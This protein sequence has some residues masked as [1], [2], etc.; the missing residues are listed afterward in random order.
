[1]ASETILVVDDSPTILK[2]VQLVLAKAGYEVLTASDGDEGLELAREHTPDLILLDFV[3]PKMNGYQV[4]QVLHN[5][6][7]LAA[8]PVVLMSA[9]GD[10]VG[11]RFV[12]VMGIVDFITKPFS[13]E[14]ITTMV[15]ET[16]AKKR[17]RTEEQAAAEALLPEPSEEELVSAADAQKE[18]RQTALSTLR[19]ALAE[20][21]RGAEGA[22]EQ[23][24]E[25]FEG[26]INKALTDTILELFL[27]ELRAN[28]PELAGATDAVLS[29]ALAAVPLGGV[30]ALLAEQLQTGVLT[31]SRATAQIDLHFKKGN[32]DLAT[33]AGMDDE[34]LLGRFVLKRGLMSEDDLGLFL[35][36]RAGSSKLLG[37]QLAK[38]GYLAV[39]ELKGALRD[40]TCELLYELLSWKEGRF[41]FRPAEQASPV[42]AEAALAIS[43]QGALMEGFRRVDQW[44]LIAQNVDNVELIFV[45]NDDALGELGRGQLTRDELAVLELVNGKNTVKD[46]IRN[47]RMSS[48][49]VSQVIH[50]LLS[51]R[52]LRRREQPVAV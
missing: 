11:D 25:A 22:P 24:A 21:L 2:V 43:V 29:G 5:E 10:Q 37:H 4:C 35:K 6:E 15:G 30:L 48:F 38:L 47:S 44:H 19:V 45:R 7:A 18:A 34:F 36:S 1:M 28:A 26:W 14:G 41:V 32:I 13:P 49:D 17:E 31:I 27:G 3:M 42:A 9:K 39:D 8:I 40:Q 51:V 12:K 20:R 52:L 16:L 33:A 46:I 23:E 50:R